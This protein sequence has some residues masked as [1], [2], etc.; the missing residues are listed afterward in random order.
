MN[1]DN[2]AKPTAPDGETER[3][4]QHTAMRRRLVQGTFEKDLEE[5]MMRHFSTDRYL[6]IG[7]PD[8]SSN[9]LEQ[10]TRQLAVLYNAPPTITNENG[11]ITPLTSFDGYINTAGF[12]QLMQRGQQ[13]TLALREC[14]VRIDVV[15]HVAGDFV[16][17]AGLQYR[18]VTPDYVYAEAHPD[19]PDEPIYYQELRLRMHPETGK[20]EWVADVIDLRNEKRP[21]FGM[22]KVKMDGSLGDDV[23]M[24]YMGH[25]THEGDD[26]PYRDK[27][28]NPFMPVE[29]YHAEK[30]G[31]L[32]DAY[33]GIQMAYGALT[34]A[35]LMSFWVHCV[36][37][38]AYPIKYTLGATPAG[39][40]VSDPELTARR[41][42]IATDPSSILMLNADME[43]G[44]Q[45]IIGQ[46]AAGADPLKLLEAISH[47][48]KRVSMSAGLSS[49]ILRESG[50]PRS[51]YALS[52]SRDGQREA[53]AKFSIS[54]SR[55]DARVLSKSAALANR[56][57]GEN[58]PETGYRVQYAK[59]PKSPAEIEATRKDVIEKLAAQL[60]SPV[61]AMQ[62][63]HGTDLDEEAAKMLLQKI[64]R[65]RAEFL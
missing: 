58:L 30:T 22:Y 46:F 60:I 25:K 57:L 48:E 28:G 61:Q 4:W 49:A 54:F 5:E 26:Y 16:R 40:S 20:G 55:H 9:I 44:G 29:L 51:G 8:L 3:R 36:R 65:E 14:F 39:L 6:A 10:I 52:V 1:I 7:V 42:T 59:L 15:P 43:A 35:T 38:C 27:N 33:S 24:T 13:L 34:S 2:Y 41:A 47:Y 11:D 37:D 17:K 23:S 50:D 21:R 32:F 62:M 64:R 45:P 63:L 18:L 31:H 19:A 53:S 56:F 12:F